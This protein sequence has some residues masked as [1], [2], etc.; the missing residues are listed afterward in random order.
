ML[1]RFNV[2]LKLGNSGWR[3][4]RLVGKEK[5]EEAAEAEAQEETKPG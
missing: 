5:E 1:A 4:R 2:Q 3:R